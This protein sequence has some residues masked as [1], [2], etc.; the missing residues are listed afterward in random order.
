ME[1][2]QLIEAYRALATPSVADAVDR[3]VGRPGFMTGAIRQ[4]VAGKV[5]GPAATVLEAPDVG[6][7]PPMHALQTIDEAQP[8]TVIVIGLDHPEG[9][10]DVALWGGIMTTAAVGR[11]LAGA[12]L[13]AGLR[14]VEEIREAGFPIFCRSL[15]PSSTVGRYVSVDRNLS[16][17][18]GGVTVDPGDL[19]VGDADGVVVVP[20]GAAEE[21][22]D[23]ARQMEQG[24]Q[25]MVEAI[26]RSGSIL[27][28]LEELGR[29]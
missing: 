29:I 8:G 9:S 14:D 13:D 20:R 26:R 11:G 4:A 25:D 27:T 24:E 16:I 5:V 22:L 12:V 18:C 10:I 28:A 1:L 19:V 6:A 17:T 23:T 15:V 3:V 7:G 2:N 21:V